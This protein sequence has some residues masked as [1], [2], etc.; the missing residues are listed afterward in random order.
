MDKK[1]KRKK[2]KTNVIQGLEKKFS[3]QILSGL[4]KDFY[5]NWRLEKMLIV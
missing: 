1:K 3:L 4:D 5:D 2:K